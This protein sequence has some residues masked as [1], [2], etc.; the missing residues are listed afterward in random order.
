MKVGVLAIQG[1]FAAHAWMIRRAGHDVVFVRRPRDLDSVAAL[2][3]PGGESTAMLRG[4]A[5][6]RL[7]NPLRSFFAS[8]RPVLATCAG[9]ILVARR[10]YHPEQPSYGAI[11]VDIERNAYGTQRDSFEAMAETDDAHAPFA[12]LRCVLIRAPRITRTGPTVCVHARVRGTPALVSDGP[13]WAATFHPELTEDTR[14][15]EA[16][17]GNGARPVYRVGA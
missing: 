2:V 9:A 10:V 5:R 1:D 3:L 15:I 12:G 11:D 17:L 4:I 7:E 14:V 13:L 16:V 8:E 6:D